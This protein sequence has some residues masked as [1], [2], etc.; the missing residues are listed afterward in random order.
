MNRYEFEDLISDY[1]EN[2]LPLLKRKEVEQYLNENPEA[3][4]LINEIRSNI[5]KVNSIPQLSVNNNFNQRLKSKLM[6]TNNQ[7]RLIEGNDKRTYFGFTFNQSLTLT[8]LSIFLIFTTIQLLNNNVEN[9][10]SARKYFS[11]ESLT[12]PK[13]PLSKQENSIPVVS[14]SN[15]DSIDVLTRQNQKRKVL[16]KI[17]FVND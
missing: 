3:Q 4:S 6:K 2:N 8:G 16:Q 12:P 17:E 15:L 5:E 11:N 14:E 13:T 9:D 1:I 10:S 7:K